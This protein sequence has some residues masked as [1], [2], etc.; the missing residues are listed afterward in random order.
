MAKNYGC[1][2]EARW[3]RIN[4]SRWVRIRIPNMD[5]DQGSKVTI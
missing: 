1:G 2:S 4:L 3:I 5:M